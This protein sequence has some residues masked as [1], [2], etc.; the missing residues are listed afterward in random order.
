VRRILGGGAIFLSIAIC[1]F[2]V[3]LWVRSYGGTDY[4]VRR[5]LV[6]RDE[7]SVQ[8]RG[9]QLS[10]T[11]GQLR[12]SRINDAGYFSGG[13]PAHRAAGPETYYGFGRLGVGHMGWES[14]QRT[15]WN[16]LGFA[17]W[18]EGWS[19]SFADWHTRSWGVP[20]WPIVFAFAVAPW[21][22]VARRVR[23]WQSVAAGRCRQCGYDLRATPARCPECGAACPP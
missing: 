11:R 3:I 19:S 10:L 14:P 23:E 8:H 1:A 6:S 16:R 15:F 20:V 4:A 22:W 21:R 9:E 13:I 7:F 12:F 5:T 17:Q 2:L 18:E